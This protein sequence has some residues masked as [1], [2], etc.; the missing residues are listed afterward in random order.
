MGRENKQKGLHDACQP[1]RLWNRRQQ[2]KDSN[3]KASREEEKI[4]REKVHVTGQKRGQNNNNSPNKL[5][6]Q[7]A[8]S[9][10]ND[11]VI[12]FMYIKIET[13]RDREMGGGEKRGKSNWI[14]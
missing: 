5:H 10:P 12:L 14:R 13:K 11:A 8:R 4:K 6:S 3:E 1:T 7:F 2:K 9:N